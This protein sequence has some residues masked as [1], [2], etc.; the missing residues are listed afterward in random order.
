MTVMPR[1]VGGATWADWLFLVGLAGLSIALYALAVV[2]LVLV[3]AGRT[4]GLGVRWEKNPDSG[5]ME[6]RVASRGGQ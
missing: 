5:A 4:L 3:G 2:A 1:K 6:T